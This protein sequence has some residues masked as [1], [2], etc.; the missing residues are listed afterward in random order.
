MEP[1][2]LALAIDDPRREAALLSLV[3]DVSFRVDGRR[4]EVS[5]LCA[6]V[7]D[8]WAAAAGDAVDAMVVASTLNALPSATL[9]DLARLGRSI[10]W[11][12]SDPLADRWDQFPVP[13]VSTE[14]DAAALMDALHEA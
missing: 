8:A 13:V 6:S 7:R 3:Q 12:A 1:L 2:R 10:V 14:P 5:E 4:C 11:L 9:R